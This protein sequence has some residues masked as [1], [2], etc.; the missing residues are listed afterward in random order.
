MLSLHRAWGETE[1]R[2]E[3]IPC[4]SCVAFRKICRVTD[5]EDFGSTDEGSQGWRKCS[6][7]SSRS[8]EGTEPGH[9]GHDLCRRRG[10]VRIIDKKEKKLLCVQISVWRLRTWKLFIEPNEHVSTAQEEKSKPSSQA[11]TAEP[12]QASPGIT[13]SVMFPVASRTT[14]PAGQWQ[15]RT[16]AAMRCKCRTTNLSVVRRKR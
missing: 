13:R 4:F 3:N 7:E 8:D 15:S 12:L 14:V 5:L 11:A 9:H 2:L 1:S 6:W 16:N 10:E